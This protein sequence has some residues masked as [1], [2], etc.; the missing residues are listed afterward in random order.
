MLIHCNSYTFLHSPNSKITNV[1]Q[2]RVKWHIYIYF[3]SVI[4]LRFII[5]QF[6]YIT[7]FSYICKLCNILYYLI[8]LVCYCYCLEATVT[9]ITPLRIIKVF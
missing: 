2:V 9:H 5:K 4:F 3:S 8:N 6:V 7:A 1:S